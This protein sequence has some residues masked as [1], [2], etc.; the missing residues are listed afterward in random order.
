M[1]TP[2]SPGKSFKDTPPQI[3]RR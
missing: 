2:I 3:R 1:K